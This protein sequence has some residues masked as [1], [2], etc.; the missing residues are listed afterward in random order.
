M[1]KSLI[2]GVDIHRKTNTYCLMDQAGV[3]QR[4][5]FTLDNNR[6]RTQQFIEQVSEVMQ[7]EEFTELR[8]AAEATGW[9]WFHFFQTLQQD[10]LL[11]A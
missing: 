10:E 1:L 6:P 5:R 2:V 3:E 4:P 7:S 8:L 9:Y 11:Q